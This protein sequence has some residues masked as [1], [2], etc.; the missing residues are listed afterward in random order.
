MRTSGGAYRWLMRLMYATDPRWEVKVDRS[1]DHRFGSRQPIRS[2][3]SF[4]YLCSKGYLTHLEGDR[5]QLTDLARINLLQEMVKRRKPD[6]K[7]RVVVFDIPEKLRQNRNVFRHHLI[8]LGFRM[9][10]QSVWVSPLPCEDLVALVVKYHGL[11]QFVELI[12]GK[13]VPLRTTAV[14]RV[15]RE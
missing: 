4:R 10:Q 3:R 14:V 5:Y 9:K 1:L 6:G 8:N 12:V 11:G 15:G 2:L 7:W 13:D